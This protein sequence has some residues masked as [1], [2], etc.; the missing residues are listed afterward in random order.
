MQWVRDHSF[1]Y[2]WRQVG[3]FFCSFK[4][5]IKMAVKKSRISTMDLT[6]DDF[7]SFLEENCSLQK[8]N[9]C[10]KVFSQNVLKTFWQRLERHFQEKLCRFCKYLQESF[11]QKLG[12][13]F[14]A[15][16]CPNW[17]FSKTGKSKSVEFS[18]IPRPC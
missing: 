17:P 5:K 11:Q 13:K 14:V 10:K 8:Q 4:N 15:R 16:T 2:G 3:I 1:F 9:I 7:L 18:I 12:R 6:N